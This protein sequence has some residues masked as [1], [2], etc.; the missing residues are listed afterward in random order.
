M[1]P[2]RKKLLRIYREE[3]RRVRRGGGRNRALGTRA[4]M[5]LPDG[6]KQ[7]S[8]L[9]FASDTFASKRLFRVLCV[10]DDYTR[11]CLALVAEK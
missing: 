2:N 8:S 10:V 9:D 5:V 6:P 4:P 1:R 3:N 11:E 7:W